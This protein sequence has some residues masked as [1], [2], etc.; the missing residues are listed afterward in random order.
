[1]T[2]Y[3]EYIDRYTVT[4]A[5]LPLIEYIEENGRTIK[6]RIYNPT[7]ADYNRLGFYQLFRDVYP[8]DGYEHTPYYEKD[9]LFIRQHWEQGEKIETPSDPTSDF[10]RTLSSADTNSIAK[11]R[12]AAKD[13]LAATE[14]AE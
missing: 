14:G 6:R 12:Q 13:F 8:D 1:M 11:I 4:P 7:E 2:Q 9:G 10:M 5:K 3:V